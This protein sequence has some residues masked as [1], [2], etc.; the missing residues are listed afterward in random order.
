M[1][2]AFIHHNLKNNETIETAF[3]SNQ[4]VSFGEFFLL[5]NKIVDQD[6]SQVLP[7]EIA[8]SF[9]LYA[10]DPKIPHFRKENLQHYFDSHGLHSLFGISHTS[11]VAGHSFLIPTVAEIKDSNNIEKSLVDM[12]VSMPHPIVIKKSGTLLREV[13]SI[14]DLRLHTLPHV[15]HGEYVECMHHPKGQ[16]L[17]CTVMRN[18]RGKEVYTTPIFEKVMNGQGSKLIAFNASDEEKQRILKNLESFFV[19]HPTIPTLHIELLKN[20]Q[21]MYLIHAT[22]INSLSKDTLPETLSAVGIG[23]LDVLNACISHASFRY[24]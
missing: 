2:V 19:N 11:T 4:E 18:T 13:S 22:T 8:E 3:T 17:V 9:D 24:L 1:R 7:S 14:H 5:K 16:K 12:W 23:S 21:G 15:L 20:K 10:L 6:G